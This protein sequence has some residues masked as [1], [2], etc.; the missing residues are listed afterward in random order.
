M[1]VAQECHAHAARQ[2]DVAL[3]QLRDKAKHEA[4]ESAADPAESSDQW[5]AGQWQ[6]TQDLEFWPWPKTL[7]DPESW[8]STMKQARIP[9]GGN[10]VKTQEQQQRTYNKQHKTNTN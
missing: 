2:L 5:Q 1:S 3:C 10:Q 6:V 7:G 8:Q 4:S 9:F